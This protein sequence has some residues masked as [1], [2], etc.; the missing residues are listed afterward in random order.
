[1]LYSSFLTCIW[2]S[3][4][5]TLAK[6]V[7]KQKFIKAVKNDSIEPRIIGGQEQSNVFPW[8]GGLLQVI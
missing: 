7:E 6:R 3:P 4:Y 8:L 5:F 1:M 2:I